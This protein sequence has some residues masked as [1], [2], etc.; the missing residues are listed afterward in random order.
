MLPS[1]NHQDGRG[2]DARDLLGKTSH[3]FQ[4]QIFNSVDRYYI[5][6]IHVTSQLPP[7]KFSNFIGPLSNP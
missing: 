2:Q 6:Q 1:V 7:S 3:F 5:V 4:L